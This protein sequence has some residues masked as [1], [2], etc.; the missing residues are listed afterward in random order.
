MT[1]LNSKL[2][3]EVLYRDDNILLVLIIG[4]DRWHSLFSGYYFRNNKGYWYSLSPEWGHLHR[5]RYKK[6]Y[7]LMEELTNDN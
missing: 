1:I 4:E 5:L 2:V 7:Q 6:Q 3:G